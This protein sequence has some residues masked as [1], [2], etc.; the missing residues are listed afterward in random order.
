MQRITG[1]FIGIVILALA[2]LVVPL[3]TRAQPPATR[4]SAS[5]TPNRRGCSRISSPASAR[6]CATPAMSKART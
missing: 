4:S 6:A 3:A 1:G 2:L 5:S